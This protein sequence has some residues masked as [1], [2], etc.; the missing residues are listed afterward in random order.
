MPSAQ[1]VDQSRVLKLSASYQITPAL[2]DEA[3][4]GYT[5][6]KQGTTNAFN[7]TAFTNS[8]GLVGLQNLFYNGIAGAG[9]QQYQFA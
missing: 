2:V 5:L 7:G 8:L 9:L 4:F 1:N 6:Y 3:G